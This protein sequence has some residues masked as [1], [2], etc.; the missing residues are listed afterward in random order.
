[1]L[2]FTALNEDLDLLAFITGRYEGRWDWFDDNGTNENQQSMTTLECMCSYEENPQK[3]STKA[4][5][6]R[7]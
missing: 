1:M 2:G 6:S 4:N 5:K 3:Q 7:N